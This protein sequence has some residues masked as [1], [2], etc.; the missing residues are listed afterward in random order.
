MEQ[1]P[2]QAMLTAV[3]HG[4]NTYHRELLSMHKHDELQGLKPEESAQTEASCQAYG[5]KYTAAVQEVPIDMEQSPLQAMLTAVSHGLNTY[6]QEL[7]SLRKRDQLEGL[8]SVESAQTEAMCQDH[9]NQCTHWAA[10]VSDLCC[11]KK[12]CCSGGMHVA[13]TCPCLYC[14][15]CLRS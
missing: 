8:E 4:P 1:S 6:H 13:C 9:H 5:N 15:S 11:C 3:S 7:L 10:T 12:P 14:E 2:L